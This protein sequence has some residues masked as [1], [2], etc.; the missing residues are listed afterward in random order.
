MN[1]LLLIS[2]YSHIAAGSLSLLTGPAAL[3]TKKGSAKH[4]LFGKIF[5]WSM[6]IVFVSGVFN[7]IFKELHF[8][9]FVGIF[10]YYNIISGIRA[11]QLRHKN[12]AKWI[13]YVIH[14]FA[15]TAMLGFVYFGIWAWEKNHIFSMLSV[16][17]GFGGLMNVRDYSGMLKRSYIHLSPLTFIRWHIGG[18][19]GGFIASVTAFSAQTMGFLPTFIQWMWPTLVFVPVIIFWKRKYNMPKL[20][21]A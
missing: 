13:D 5:F 12:G 21:N 17:F 20:Q 9:T 10:S 7:A 18:L 11:L 16:I 14:L 2:L 19:V 6:T 1:T 15:L 3:F 4:I 8:L